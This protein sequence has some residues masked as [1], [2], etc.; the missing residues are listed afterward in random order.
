M[1]LP[2]DTIV[3]FHYHD[4]VQVPFYYALLK[5][6]G[7]PHEFHAERFENYDFNNLAPEG[8]FAFFVD[9]IDREALA[10]LEALWY[11][12]GPYFDAGS[13]LPEHQQFGLYL[14]TPLLRR[15]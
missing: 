14:V 1:K 9:P 4:P 15:S 13:G 3:Y 2:A 5:Y 11:L 7:D 8:R 10:K 12:D 6:M